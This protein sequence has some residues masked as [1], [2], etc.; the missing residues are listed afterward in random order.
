MHQN[1]QFNNRASFVNCHVHYFYSSNVLT[2]S[3][4]FL[5]EDEWRHIK[6]LR[7]RSGEKVVITD[8]QGGHMVAEFQ[9]LDK[10]P[11]LHPQKL[12][13]RPKES[14]GLNVGIPVTQDV[15]R[16]EW[17]IEK[18]IE[19]GIHVIHLLKTHNTIPVKFSMERFQKIAISAMKQSQRN[20]LPKI[21]QVQDWRSLV[22]QYPKNNVFYAHCYQGEKR[23]WSEVLS[24]HESPLLLIGPEGDF[25]R[26]EVD[27]L[28]LLQATPVSLGKFRL[29]TETAALMAV[30][31]FYEL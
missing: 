31:K 2:T 23:K 26:E 14:R 28:N 17:F 5:S 6:A 1:Y 16:V 4:F 8:G 3:S 25:T 15:D 18:S 22:N 9:L 30:A 21:E 29:R 19:L 24:I 20:W 7:I 12:D 10:V 11:Q 13:F 27:E